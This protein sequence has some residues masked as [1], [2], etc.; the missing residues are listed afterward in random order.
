MNTDLTKKWAKE[1]ALMSDADFEENCKHIETLLNRRKQ[2]LRK[3]AKQ[4]LIINRDVSAA[5][6]KTAV[7]RWPFSQ[8]K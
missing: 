8:H 1:I 6:A 4:K 2:A 7:S 5:I 3:A